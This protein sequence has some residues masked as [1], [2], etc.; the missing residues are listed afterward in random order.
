MK[1]LS[2]L[3]ILFAMAACNSGQKK[4]TTASS[5]EQTPGK[6]VIYVSESG[7][8]KFVLEELNKEEIKLTD[9]KT[10]ESYNLVHVAS[11]SGAKYSNEAGY[12]FWTKGREFMWMKDDELIAA[13]KQLAKD[14][15]GDYANSDYQKRDEGYDWVGVKVSDKGNEQLLFR[16]RSRA[17]RK[18][19]TCTWDATAY[20]QEEGVYF[21][22]VDGKRIL[23]HFSGDTLEIAPQNPADQNLLYFYCSGG[24]TVAGTYLKIDGQLDPEQV[25]ST[26]FSKVL[27]LQGI[28]F[29]V[30]S[31]RKG[32]QTQVTVAPFGLEK[33]NRVETYTIDGYIT[34][35]E[36][37]D[38]NADGSPELLIYTCSF[39]SGSYGN[40][41][42]FSVN[43]RKSVSMA[44]LPP[45]AENPA[46]NKGYMGHD[47]FRVVENYLVQRFPVYNEGDSNANPTGGIRQ[48]TY[49]LEEGEAMRQFK[50]KD[51]MTFER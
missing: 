46:L 27:Q 9:E 47:E 40:V 37:E 18:K 39:G 28:G 23:F 21:T 31:V 10:D 43:N 34:D 4:N 11:A 3:V 44:Y 26:V 41:L 1:I 13:G 22:M 48:I 8:H 19:P 45:V 14:F 6:Q 33:S 35:A 32:P 17:D 20:R 25:D 2:I 42:A 30:S 29:N 50:V 24:A 16:V 7:Q 38:L 12:T 5:E 15:T 51:I 36:I 49:T